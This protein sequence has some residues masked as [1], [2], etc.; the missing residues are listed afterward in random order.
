MTIRSS[1]INKTQKN[2]LKEMSN[3]LSYDEKNTTMHKCSINKE[4]NQ[5]HIQKN[6]RILL[7]DDEPD[8]ILV[9]KLV[10]EENGFKVDSFTDA[11]E[12]LKKF[13]TGIYDLVIV[14][15]K[16]PAIDGFSLYEKIKKLDGKVIICFLT[17]AGDAYYEILKKRYPTINEKC[18][19]RKPVDNESLIRQIKSILKR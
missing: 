4:S 1:P 3:N 11:S 13:R 7:V 9:M 2:R 6:S 8:I 10:L 15:V 5:Q 19:I 12:A 17:A 16:M 18:V 14:D